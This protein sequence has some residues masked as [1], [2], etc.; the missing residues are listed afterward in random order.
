MRK[1][2]NNAALVPVDVQV[3]Y[4]HAKIGN[5]TETTARKARKLGHLAQDF[6]DAGLKIVPVYFITDNRP[7]SKIDYYGYTP[8]KDD[9]KP[10][11]KSSPS[12][13]GATSLVKNL[14]D[15][16]TKTVYLCGFKFNACVM[17]T[18]LDLKA[19]GFNVYIIKDLSGIG[20]G[21]GNT[22]QKIRQAEKEMKKAGIKFT[23][24]DKMLHPAPRK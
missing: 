8:S 15:M 16:K 4:A 12:A 14:H 10:L 5:G 23:N 18:A 20:L 6:R 11:R 13:V 9:A 7:D 17:E 1:L 24:S 2:F 19:E 22:T 21:Y 3:L